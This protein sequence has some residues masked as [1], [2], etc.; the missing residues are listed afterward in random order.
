MQNMEKEKHILILGAGLAGLSAAFELVKKGKAVTVLEKEDVAG[1]LCRS[2]NKEGFVFDIGGHRI[3][4]YEE[5]VLDTLLELLGSELKEVKRTSRIKFNN[6]Y[7]DYPLNFSAVFSLGPLKA[8]KILASYALSA[9]AGSKNEANDLSFEGWIVNRFGSELY[10]IYFKPY[11]EKV[12][13]IPCKELSPDWAVQR[14]SLLNLY[15]AV[16]KALFRP[17]R[18]PRTYASRFYYPKGGIG[19]LAK[20][21]EAGIVAKGGRV[22]KGHRVESLSITEGRVSFVMVNN[23]SGALKLEAGQFVSTIPI[24][25]LI[26]KLTPAVP[27]SLVEAAK[28]LSYRSVICLLLAIDKE[29]VTKDTWIYFPD[30]HLLFSRVHEPKNWSSGLSREGKTS[31]C[32]EVMCDEGDAVWTKKD[33]ELISEAVEQLTHLRLFKKEEVISSHVERVPFAYPIYKV[34]YKGHLDKIMGH[35]SSISNLHLVGR[36]GTFQYLNMDHVIKEGGS[37]ARELVL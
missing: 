17:A 15:D 8:A 1:G 20:A 33:E 23:S 22:L 32:V 3:L 29:R 7:V 12:W 16:R 11:T 30:E 14:I 13:G 37:V 18:R 27:A 4:P 31:L 2:F 21:F 6:R 26:N 35:L 19:A 28:G 34:G 36:T 9:I 24:T 25:E 10:N 5:G